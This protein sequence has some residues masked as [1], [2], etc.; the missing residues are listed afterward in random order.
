MKDFEEVFYSY[1]IEVQGSNPV[2]IP[3]DIDVIEE[4]HLARS[5]RRGATTRAQNAGVSGSDIDW[6]NRWGKGDA[7]VVKG[8]MRVVYSERRQLLPSY[9]RFSKAL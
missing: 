6:I 2:L 8:P 3:P 9:L 7:H 5:F 1:L 4:Y